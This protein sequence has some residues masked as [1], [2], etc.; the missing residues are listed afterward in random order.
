[1]H[2]MPCNAGAND[3]AADNDYVRCLHAIWALTPPTA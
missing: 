1:V 3:A 2:E